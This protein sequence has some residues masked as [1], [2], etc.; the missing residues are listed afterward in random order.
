[1]SILKE[2]TAKRNEQRSALCQRFF[3]TGKGEY[4]EG[5]KFLGLTM[6]QIRLIA[7]KHSNATLSEVQELLD[8]KYHEHRMAGLMILTLK[9]PK[10]NSGIF[11]FYV[12]NLNKI[13]NW[14]LVDV[15]CPRIIG[16]YL[17]DKN[18]SFLYELAESKN[19]WKKRISVVSTFAFIKRND[20]NDALK[21]S[22]TLLKDGHDLIHKAVGWVL[23][24]V[25][26]KDKSALENFLNMNYNEMPRTTLRYAIER[27]PEAERKAFLHGKSLNASRP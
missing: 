27:F 16:E 17:V 7:R 5:D 20:F 22:R 21:I 18:R 11:N 14:D 2:V 13:N 12:K 4:G 9:Y 25:G 8:S 1:M 26:K 19:L 3:K 24:E 10:D 15:T 6:P 23:R